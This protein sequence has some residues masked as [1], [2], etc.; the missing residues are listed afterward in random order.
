MKAKGN[1]IGQLRH[2]AYFQTLTTSK[3]ANGAEVISWS[4]GSEFWCNIE[5]KTVG[6]DED[7]TGRRIQP[8]TRAVV[9]MRYD[10]TVDEKMRIVLDTKEY[11]I[12]TI[13]PDV[14]RM[15]M[16]LDCVRDD[17]G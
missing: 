4:N 7:L 16:V 10:S 3:D 1:T 14:H 2:R 9:K 6:S 12:E 15:Y 17:E 11:N 13:A 8:F 5:Y